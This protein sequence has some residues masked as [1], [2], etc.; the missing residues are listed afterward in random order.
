MPEGSLAD[1]VHRLAAK[2]VAVTRGPLERHA[3]IHQ[4]VAPGETEPT[5]DS[6]E[7]GPADTAAAWAAMTR[8]VLETHCT[9]CCVCGEAAGGLAARRHKVLEEVDDDPHAVVLLVDLVG[10]RVRRDLAQHLCMISCTQPDGEARD[11]RSIVVQGVERGSCYS[12]RARRRRGL[13]LSVIP[14]QRRAL[15]P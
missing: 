14:R 1:E 3:K 11:G 15:S 8:H 9:P 2:L 7:D 10:Q 13:A 5:P 6:T 12:G 4:P